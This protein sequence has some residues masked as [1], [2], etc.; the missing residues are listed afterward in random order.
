MD[1]KTGLRQ[2]LEEFAHHKLR[3]MLTLLGMIF[4]V[5]AV[6]SMLAIGKGAERQ[7]LGMIDALGL[8]NVIV[9][10]IPQPEERLTEIREESLGLT[11]SHE[12]EEA[13]GCTETLTP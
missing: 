13:R 3:T 2:A 1:W 9:E 6:I 12:F 10:A 5:G 4:G 8:R 11:R 7:A